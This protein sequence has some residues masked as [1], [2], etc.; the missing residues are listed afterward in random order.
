VG[1]TRPEVA[2]TIGP[3]RPINEGHRRLEFVE[4]GGGAAA[5][6]GGAAA[7]AGGAAASA[8]GAI[9]DAPTTDAEPA[10]RPLAPRSPVTPLSSGGEPG[11]SLWG[12]L[13]R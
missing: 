6:A 10:L 1:M 9:S 4:V 12:D 8:G 13:D 11:W 5:S 7:S 3:A 2:P